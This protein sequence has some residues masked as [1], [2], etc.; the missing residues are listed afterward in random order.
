MKKLQ[1]KTWEKVVVA[2]GLLLFLLALG[3]YLSGFPLR[4]YLFGLKDLGGGKLVGNAARLNGTVKRE[5]VGQS[6]FRT[7]HTSEDLYEADTIVTSPDSGA[8]IKLQDGSTIELGPST[9]IKLEGEP[10]F[11]LGGITQMTRVQVVNGKVTGQGAENSKLVIATGDI[12]EQVE[13]NSPVV[14]TASNE[15][16]EIPKGTGTSEPSTFQSLWDRL[17]GKKEA[18]TSNQPAPKPTPI[19][20]PHPSPKPSPSPSPS[21]KPP[22]PS[23]SPSPTPPTFHEKIVLI[24]PAN[25]SKQDVPNG[26][27]VPQK[28]IHL[29]W[30][31][32]GVPRLAR[33][34]KRPHATLEVATYSGGKRMVLMSHDANFENG[35]HDLSWTATAPGDY[36]WTIKVEG[37]P[38]I[39]PNRF[40]IDPDFIAIRVLPPESIIGQSPEGLAISKTKLS[41]Q[42]YP[43][44]TVYSVKLLNS[45]NPT[46][47]FAETTTPSNEVRLTQTRPDKS[48]GFFEVSTQLPSGFIVHSSV[49]RFIFNFA[50]PEATSPQDKSI[51]SRKNDDLDENGI[52]LAWRKT[53]VSEAYV[54]EIASDPD[55]K[56]LVVK[57]MQ[58]DNFFAFK[59]AKP[60][61]ANPFKPSVFYWRVF[62]YANRTL[63]KPSKVS[64]FAV[65]K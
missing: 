33:G 52:L 15:R 46:D 35:P 43:T 11:T 19:S 30:Q 21:P 27:T 2:L 58:K 9:M 40:S 18:L 45:T 42:A 32:N 49:E 14:M 53:G 54:L 7:I 59:L 62:A 26:S 51:L 61:A 4:N 55:F 22:A 31:I 1:L 24:E 8:T 39:T 41:W 64:R 47:S 60:T 13:K 12:E 38:P 34:Q 56:Q 37:Q 25:L 63:S 28:N 44:A 3:L 17:R 10:V 29:V 20:I 50:P 65:K 5:F 23:P 6:D 36:E 57:R 16:P 48:Q